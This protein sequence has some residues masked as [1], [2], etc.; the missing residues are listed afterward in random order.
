MS[1]KTDP[2]GSQAARMEVVSTRTFAH[3][4]EA[5]FDAFADP[6]QLARWWGPNGFTTTIHE[7][8]LR[9]G[10]AWR[11]VMHGPNGSDYE[12]T[13]EFVEIVRPERIVF[14]HL[15]PVHQFRMTMTLEDVDGRTKV[16][17]RMQFEADERNEKLRPFIVSGNEENFDR[18]A[19]HVASRQQP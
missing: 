5:L 15:R 14:D 13:S 11:F 10:G 18:L 1:T 3:R 8:D 17:W 6:A 7:F 12:N 4:R 9:P 19:A 2:T 16:T